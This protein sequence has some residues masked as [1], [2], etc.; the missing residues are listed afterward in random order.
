MRMWR[1]RCSTSGRSWPSKRGSRSVRQS[2]HLNL[3]LLVRFLLCVR[4]ASNPSRGATPQTRKSYHLHEEDG[5][6]CLERGRMVGSVRAS[7]SPIPPDS[8][9]KPIRGARRRGLRVSEGSTGA[10][11]SPDNQQC[12][13]RIEHLPLLVEGV[14]MAIADSMAQLFAN[15]RNRLESHIHFLCR[16]LE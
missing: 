1:W 14:D 9:S 16:Y 2:P 10:R 3:I 8:S 6:R 15:D 5:R 4:L 11:A 7:G 13:H 12:N